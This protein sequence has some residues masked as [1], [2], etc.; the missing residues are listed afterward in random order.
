MSKAMA[1]G[2]FEKLK[3]PEVRTDAALALLIGADSDTAK[4]TLATFNDAGP[5]AMEELKVVYNQTFGYWSDRN[6]ENGDVARWIENAQACRH[7]KVRDALQDWPSLLLSRAIQGID[8]D[9]GPRS[10]T[11][12][13]FRVM[14]L[15][16]A[17]S[18][19]EKKRTNALQILKFMKEKGVLM[20]LKS[21]PGPWQDQ[22]RQMFFEVM[23]PKLTGEKLPDAPDQKGAGGA[24]VVAPKK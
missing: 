11:R 20:A 9:N 15:R 21:E 3:N 22:A 7:V 16:D 6:Y 4:R 2:L 5:E 1:D 24:N 17:K 12:V 14:L 13:R 8:F 10:I 23:N 18:T 19:D